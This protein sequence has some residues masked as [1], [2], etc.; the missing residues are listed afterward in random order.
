VA[1]RFISDLGRAELPCDEDGLASLEDIL[2]A[3]LEQLRKQALPY[4]RQL[5]RVAL[6]R[7]LPAF[8]DRERDYRVGTRALPLY[9]ELAFGDSGAARAEGE[10]PDPASTA[11]PL[12]ILLDGGGSVQIHGR[13]DRVDTTPE[14]VAVVLDYKMGSGRR[15][16]DM[17]DGRSLQMPLYFMALEQLFNI[18]VGASFYDSFDRN[19]RFVAA[20]LPEQV[21]R[22]FTQRARAN[23]NMLRIGQLPDLMKT[24]SETVR[25]VAA[26]L[27]ECRIEPVSGDHC[28]WCTFGDLCRCSA[29]RNSGTAG[30]AGGS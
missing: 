3:E 25:R 29:K 28:N 18:P 1:G 15:L 5:L 7:L 9:C 23:G 19:E 6:L 20:A 11:I 2:D 10:D 8:L 17:L 12:S 24:A 22:V 14:G 21:P 26:D 13:V 27:S 16:A 30:G 4:Q